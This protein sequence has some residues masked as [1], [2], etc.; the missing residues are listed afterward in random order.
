MT[1]TA[2]LLSGTIMTTMMRTR[3]IC[4]QYWQRPTSKTPILQ[5]VGMGPPVGVG[6]SSLLVTPKINGEIGAMNAESVLVGIDKHSKP[7]DGLNG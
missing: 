3:N 5:G 2:V 1:D 6:I 4:G 7:C